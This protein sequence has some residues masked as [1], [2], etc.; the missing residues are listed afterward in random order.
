[1]PTANIKQQQQMLQKQTQEVL[2][3]MDIA[4]R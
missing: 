4:K 3:K 1:M 2:L